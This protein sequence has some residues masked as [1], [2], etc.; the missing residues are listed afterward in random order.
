MNVNTNNITAELLFLGTS[1]CEFGKRLQTDLKDKFD[2]DVRRS[3][4]MLINGS[5]LVDC[6]VHTE[7]SLAIAE[8]DASKITDAF[9]THLHMDHYNPES[10]A[11][12]ARGR[13]E[14]LRLW[15]REG[16]DICEMENVSVIRMTPFKEYPIPGGTVTSVPANH[17]PIA[18]PQHFIFDIGKKIFYGCDGAWFLNE[19]FIF[20][21]NKQLDAAV[22]D[23]T[24]GDYVGDFR[25]G[26]HNS[27]PMLRLMLPSMLNVK[28]ISEN[29]K[30]IL[31]HLAP[32]LHKSHSETEKI[33]GD[34]G[35]T[36]AYDGM[37]IQI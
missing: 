10:I 34:L 17:D 25:L 5:L 18:H 24:V 14:P 3:S 31:S 22:L 21:K 7:E 12:I 19:S 23:C 30:I 13:A 37:R 16:A 32:S 29:T 26:E 1:A 15:V 20:M 9:I 28:M 6:G 36:V 35:A 11:R 33:A 27:I 2:K 8:V 4:A